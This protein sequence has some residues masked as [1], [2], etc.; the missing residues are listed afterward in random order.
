MPISS[1][2]SPIYIKMLLYW[3]CTKNYLSDDRQALRQLNFKVSSMQKRFL[4]CLHIFIY[5]I[6]FACNTRTFPPNVERTLKMAGN[7]RAELEKA[8]ANYSK[9]AEDSLKL[10][11]TYFIIANLDGWYYYDGELL[12]HYQDYLK[13]IRQDQDHGAYFLNSFSTLYGPFSTGHLSR[14]YDCREISA[15]ELIG[16]IELAF[17]VWEEQPWG[18]DVS[19]DQFCEYIL[20]FRIQNEIPAYNR[21]QIYEEFYDK[22]DYARAKK[23]GVI[24]A[25]ISLNEELKKTA[26]IFSLRTSFL[27][28]Y[29]AARIVKYRVGSC[30]EM[31]D[32]AFYVMRATG[33]PVAIDFV[34]QWPYRSMGH[35]FNVILDK[36][37]KSMIFL[38]SEDDPGENHK[39]LTKKGKVYRHMFTKDSGSLAMLKKDDDV[40]PAFLEDSRIKDVTDQY[41]KCFNVN[42]HLDTVASLAAGIKKYAYICV[43]DNKV[44]QPIHWSSALNG[45]AVFTKM[46]GEIVYLVGY[47]DGSGIISAGF[48]FILDKEGNMQTLQPDLVRRNKQMV[49]SRVFPVV[50]DDFDNWHMEGCRFQGANKIDFS[51]AKDLYKIP[52]KPDPFWN[53]ITINENN[54]FRYVRYFATDYTHIGEMEFFSSGGK[55]SGRAFGTKVGWY[56]EKTFEKAV[57]GDLYTSFDP[58][59]APND[60]A[61]SWVGLDFGKRMRI[62]KIRF[63][64]PLQEDITV[65]VIIGNT[66]ELFYW[67][68]SQWVSAGRKTASTPEVTFENV[69]SN[70][71]YMLRDNTRQIEE[72]I[73]TYKNGNVIFW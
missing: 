60:S 21:K 69:P 56:K 23:A 72:R 31:S 29:N 4:F 12:D 17:K 24:A 47:Y 48:P 25:G 68:H 63:S 27:P 43:F 58:A 73:F 64:A 59:G 14:K 30:R 20:P 66:Y 13:L 54:T 71:L 62:S 53:V 51:D 5:S 26:W 11:A 2:S 8:I 39:A 6:I 32:L 35:E 45:H 65:K 41:V 9:N 7:N 50:P 70:A 3:Y 33:I 67:D 16:N 42:A 49:L 34:P 57:D 22:L 38:G 55:L 61:G 1:Q 36:Y 46:E 10:M 18:K 40:V 15:S 44:W 37:G 52:S 28:H 19:F